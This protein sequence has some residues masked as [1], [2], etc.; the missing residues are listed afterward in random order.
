M[1]HDIENVEFIPRVLSALP[2]YNGMKNQ[3]YIYETLKYVGILTKE[4]S[5]RPNNQG[6]RREWYRH[7]KC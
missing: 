4:F 2:M 3:E 7:H 5:L 6:G 1:K